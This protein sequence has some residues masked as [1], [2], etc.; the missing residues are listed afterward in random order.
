MLYILD[1][2]ANLPPG[3]APPSLETLLVPPL[4]FIIYGVLGPL[5]YI[6]VLVVGI[7]L[8]WPGGTKARHWL[9]KRRTVERP[10]SSSLSADSTFLFQCVVGGFI[11]LAAWSLVITSWLAG[12]LH[13]ARAPQ[14]S[15]AQAS[16]AN[17]AIFVITLGIG[18]L[19]GYS[20]ATGMRRTR[21]SQMA[22]AVI[23]ASMSVAGSL[24]FF[25]AVEDGMRDLL[26]V[27]ALGVF[28]GE[29]AVAAGH[30]MLLGEGLFAELL[31]RA[32]APDTSDEEGQPGE[33]DVE[34][35]GEWPDEHR[36]SADSHDRF[37]GVGT[38][39][40]APAEEPD[41]LNP[42]SGSG[43]ITERPS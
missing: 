20:W 37:V 8:A 39:S 2:L 33:G 38:T 12:Y 36:G 30:P 42:T 11:A 14:L 40:Q 4:R 24:L 34:P 29:L 26:L 21:T 10:A 32:T 35:A 25:Y 31:I 27:L 13:G 1:V 15:A 7:E 9:L 28:V 43:G 5:V 17:A 22:L 3:H 16:P 41:A 6:S 19:G 23:A 18:L